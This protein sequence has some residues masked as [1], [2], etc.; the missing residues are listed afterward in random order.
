MWNQVKENYTE[1]EMDLE[2]K[3]DIASGMMT[4]SRENSNK[5]LAIYQLVFAALT[6]TLLI[7]P[8]L[9]QRLADKIKIIWSY[10]ENMF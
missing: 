3:I 9:A 4:Y 2:R 10:I 5:R 7:F 8:E 1:I 6:F